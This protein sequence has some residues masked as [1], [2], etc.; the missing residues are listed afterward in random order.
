MMD[1]LWTIAAFVVT[2]GILVSFHEFGHF[3]VARRAGVKVLTFSVGFGR[4]LW[5]RE[6]KDGTVYQLGMIPLGGY[7]RMLDSRVDE[8]PA[9]QRHLAFNH[10]SVAKRF[11]VVAAGPLANFVLA[12]AVLWLMFV[13]GVPSVKPIIGELQANSIAA[14]SG[15]PARAEITSIAGQDTH[16]WE[17]VHMALAS[18]IGDA[19]TDVTVRMANGEERLYR[20]D[21][22]N[23]QYDPQTQAAFQSVGIEVYRP[24]VYTDIVE[25]AADSPA[26]KAGF[27]AGDKIVAIDGTLI[28]EWSQ[29]RE[30]IADSAGQVRQFSVQR[31]GQRQ[32]IDVM[33]GSRNERGFLGVVPRAD[34]YPEAYLFT[35]QY[36]PF[37]AIAEGAKRTWDLI[38]LSFKMIG[39]LLTGDVSVKNLAGPISIAEGA[40]AQAATGFVYFL[41]FL[42]LLS[43]NLGII[44]LLPLPVLDGGHLL[45]F[46]IEWVRGKPLSEKVQDICYRIGGAL[47]FLLMAIAIT[48]DITRLAL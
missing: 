5:R 42:A 39:K 4:P 20:L 36:G 12:V 25:I 45:F 16:N 3:W 40:G 30:L 38:V 32:Q 33:I 29:I 22:T 2:L 44:N 17:Q 6:A 10:K 43:V 21:L 48:N 23:W 11:A 19:S 14:E 31:D 13:I 26:A 37:T 1:V 46:V 18:A 15:L 7:V 35:Q 47:V 8:V 41:G 28:S 24:Q 34:A 9:E 27:Q